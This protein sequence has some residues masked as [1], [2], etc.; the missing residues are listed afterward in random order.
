MPFNYDFQD[1]TGMTIEDRRTGLGMTKVDCE[2]H[3]KYFFDV[4]AGGWSGNLW[5]NL[6]V[7]KRSQFYFFVPLLSTSW[8]TVFSFWP[9][10]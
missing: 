9:Q 10:G 3:R 1:N 5:L 7:A 6:N 4:R 2:E 8:L